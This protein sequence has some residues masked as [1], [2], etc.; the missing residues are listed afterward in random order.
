MTVTSNYDVTNSTHQMPLNES[1]HENFLRTSLLYIRHK[2]LERA[3]N[4]ALPLAPFRTDTP[5]HFASLNIGSLSYSV[6]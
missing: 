3:H 2:F 6:G 4:S 1:P 5:L